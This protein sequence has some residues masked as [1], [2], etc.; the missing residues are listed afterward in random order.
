MHAKCVRL[1]L[2]ASSTA[3]VLGDVRNCLIGRRHQS[4]LQ[5]DVPIEVIAPG[6]MQMVG[7]E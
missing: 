3:G 2:R 5:L 1:A 6:L 4:I 7:R